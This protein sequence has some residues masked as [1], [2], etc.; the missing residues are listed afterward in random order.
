MTQS[1]SILHAIDTTGPGGAETVFLDLAEKLQI[2]GYS[3][4]AII[5]GAGWVEEQLQKRNIYNCPGF[6]QNS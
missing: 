3:N 4:Y 5:K 6:L 2:D 1:P